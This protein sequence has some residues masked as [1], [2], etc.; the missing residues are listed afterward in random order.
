MEK[1]ESEKETIRYPID[2]RVC[3]VKAGNA[4]YAKAGMPDK[5]KQFF[6]ETLERCHHNRSGSRSE[7]GKLLEGCVGRVPAGSQIMRSENSRPL[8]LTGVERRGGMERFG[9]QER[10]KRMVGDDYA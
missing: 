6:I 7:L 4:V 8:T 5:G 9:K 2:D 3:L 1:G 10:P